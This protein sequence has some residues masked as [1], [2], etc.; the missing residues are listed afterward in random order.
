MAQALVGLVNSCLGENSV[1]V[2]A[3]VPQVRLS[4]LLKPAEQ[5]GKAP[6]ATLREP[7]SFIRAGWPGDVPQNLG[8]AGDTLR[9][10]HSQRGKEKMGGIL[11]SLHA[12]GAT[13]LF[14]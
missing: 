5:S 14:T 8:T 9:N 2:G 3:P 6:R 12:I 10:K 4:Q 13:S 1:S 11:G 7:P